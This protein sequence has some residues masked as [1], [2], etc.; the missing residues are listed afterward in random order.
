MD[1]YLDDPFPVFSEERERLLLTLVSRVMQV[2]QVLWGN[3]QRDGV[4]ARFRGRIV[5]DTEAAYDA[6]AAALRPYELTPIF[7]PWEGQHEIVLVE[8]L[9]RPQPSNPWVNL[10]LF[11]ATAF[12]VFL[13][14][15]L[16]AYDGPLT[17][18]PAARPYLLRALGGGLAFT[19]SLL[20]ILLAHE[21]G[22]YLAARY[23]GTAVTLPYFIPFPFSYF[24]TLG[25]FI[26]LKAPPKN[27]RVLLDI[28]LAGPLAGLVVAVPVLLLGLYLS[29][30]APLPVALSGREGLVLEGNSLFYLLAKWLVKGH[31]LPQPPTYGGLSPLAYWLRYL[32]TGRPLPL[33][34]VDVMLHPVAW[35]GWAGL[36]VTALNLLPAGTLDGG[37]VLYSLLGRRAAQVFPWVMAA[38]FLLGWF[39]S[40][41]W[42]WMAMLFFLGRVYAEPLDRITPLDPKRRFWAWMGLGIFVLLF[43]PVPLQMV[44]P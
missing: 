13:A 4:V 37:H 26:R 38:L 23:H 12:S 43:T 31:W 34:G 25:A 39:W 16:Y 2:G 40:G 9:I 8:G 5:G 3:P 42:L 10:V 30:L 22:H 35:A 27:R 24:G 28:G 17:L 36:L 14:G 44:F 33:G 6:L 15:V 32:F 18:G 1:P 19:V 20:A 7:Q 41:W 11:V 29:P 21:F